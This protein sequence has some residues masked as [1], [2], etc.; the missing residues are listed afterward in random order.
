MS[1]WKRLAVFAVILLGVLVIVPFLIPMSS[2]ITQAE[3]LATAELGVP[4]KL[5]SMR[6]ALLPTPRLNVS[7]ILIGEN[8]DLRVD[9]VA[10]VPALSSLFSETKVLSRVEVDKPIIK[11]SALALLDAIAKGE[12][13]PQKPAAVAVRKIEIN[14]AKLVWPDMALPEFDAEIAM[15][16]E[17]EPESVLIQTTDGK[18]KLDL[19]PQEQGVQAITLTAADWTIP[20]GSPLLVNQLKANML[21]H[22]NVLEITSLDAGLYQGKVTGSA[23]LNWAKDWRVAGKLKIDSLAVKEPARI[24]SKGTHVSGNLF[25]NGTYSAS[26]KEPG[27]LA[28]KLVANFRFNVKDGVLY[29]VDLTN[30]A[31]LLLRQGEKGGETQFDEFSGIAVVNGKQYLFKDLKI[32]S[33]LMSADGHVKIMPDKTLDGVTKVKVKNSATLAEMPLRISG[34]LDKPS[35]FPTK[36]ALAGAAAGA[37]VGGPLGAGLGIKAAEGVEKLRKGLFGSDEE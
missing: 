23:T 10:V 22:E 37:A 13:E 34:T 4:V 21:L 32:S 1:K 24:M 11:E 30:A 5:K 6:L 31:S 25:S 20:V 19:T 36:A 7:G 17:N 18:L 16:A 29:G 2:Y 14:D 35:L 8:E 3:Q 12:D 27:L 33:G 28:Q 9:D 15:T 26:A